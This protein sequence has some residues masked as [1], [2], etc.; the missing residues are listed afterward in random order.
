MAGEYVPVPEV[1]SVAPTTYCPGVRSAKVWDPLRAW[2]YPLGP[3]TVIAAFIPAASPLTVTARLPEDGPA[4]CSAPPHAA[5]STPEAARRP[6]QAL[7]ER[8]RTPR[9]G[10]RRPDS[11]IM[12]SIPRRFA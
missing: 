12:T 6:R 1:T 10:G 7:R 8:A 11:R 3:V 4:S 5:M 2:L 9:S